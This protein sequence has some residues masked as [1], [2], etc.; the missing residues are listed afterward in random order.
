M[1]VAHLLLGV[2]LQRDEAGLRQAKLAPRNDCW[3]GPLLPAEVQTRELEVKL[4]PALLRNKVAQLAFQ[5]GTLGV[6]VRLRGQPTGRAGTEGGSGSALLSENCCRDQPTRKDGAGV[7]GSA[8][9]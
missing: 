9:P 7:S 4:P 2:G 5:S 1:H 6:P 3:C 8:L